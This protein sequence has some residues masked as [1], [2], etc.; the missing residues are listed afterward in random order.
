MEKE[1][2]NQIIVQLVRSIN[3]NSKKDFYQVIDRYLKTLTFGG[4]AY[5]DVKYFLQQRPME[6]IQLD[7]LGKDLSNLIEPVTYNL[8]EV[9][10]SDEIG[11]LVE[12]LKLE[13]A[14]KEIFLD[15]KL[16]VR[17]KIL[18]YGP[19]GNGKTTIARYMAQALN[20]PFVEVKTGTLIGKNI[21]ETS[22]QISNIFTKLN[23]P[24]VVFW[25]EIDSVGAKRQDLDNG[26]AA[27]QENIRIVNTFLTYFEKMHQDVVFIGATNRLQALDSAFVRRFD[28]KMEV[29]NPSAQEKARFLDQ[30]TSYYNF[31]PLECIQASADIT[32][33]QSYAEIKEYCLGVVRN[34]VLKKIATL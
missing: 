14:H 21:G 31:P 29:K 7:N 5:N 4:K 25:D 13:H 27:S 19:T 24:C 17:N 18:F 12:S 33:L 9:F 20:I 2:P 1:T 28:I 11:K 8:G 3:M 30:L 34:I 32:S 15:H 23:A 10:L 22:A 26:S 16:N 6:M